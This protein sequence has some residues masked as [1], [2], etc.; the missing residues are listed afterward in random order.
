MPQT[1]Y[2][3]DNVAALAGQAVER[4]RVCGKYQAAEEIPPGRFVVLNSDGK[5][6]LPQDTALGKVVGVSMY[7]SAK[8]PG[9]WAIDDYVPVLRAGTIWVES[10]ASAPADLASANVRH[11][12]TTS[13][14]RGKVTDAAVSGAAGS[15]ISDPGPVLFYDVGSSAPSGL[16]LVELAF[17]GVDSDDDT[18]LDALETDAATANASMSIPLASF[19]DADG[20]P[21]AKFVSAASPTFGFNLAD[22]EALNLR[23][24][25]DATPGTALCQIAIPKD[26]DDT[27]NAY[28]EFLCSK[29]GATLADATTLTIAAYIVAEGNLHD[30]DANC[31]GVTAALVGDAAAKTTDKLSLTIAA[32][33]I[34]SGAESMTFTVTPTAGT[35]GTDD[36]MIHAVR[37]KY[38][39][40]IQTS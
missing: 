6:E 18:R 24:N 34:P 23:W 17:P 28:L 7:R 40:K 3:L 22:S 16:A 8:E 21:L 33:D 20:D 38:T 12:S 27:A 5:L 29:S 30:A 31:G 13:T 11:S 32:A 19:L 14:H 9:A 35:L 25:N 4:G 36:L 15:E 37:L 2:N 26:L 1:D 39:R 10:T